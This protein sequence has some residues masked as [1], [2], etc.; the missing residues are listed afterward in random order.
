MSVYRMV[1]EMKVLNKTLF[2]NCC[3]M[4]IIAFVYL[5]AFGPMGKI[6]DGPVLK[7]CTGGENI[8]LQIAVTQDSDIQAY[9][10]KL[11]RSGAFG[12]FFFCEQCGF[13]S[14][15][16]EE[17]KERGHAVGLYVCSEHKGQKTDMYIGGGHSVPVLH[18][19]QNGSLRQIGPSID[20]E[21]L[22]NMSNW[23]QLFSDSLKGDMFIRIV[24]DNQ[25]DEFEKVVQ[26]V[27]DKGYT[28][29]KVDEML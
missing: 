7:G 22:R 29:L 21:R 8:A 2:S 23:L 26:I 9:M 15:D 3:L 1:K 10:E 13:G 6:S 17:I 14:A 4:L 28:I 20:L 19:F 18:Y 12:T 25:F 5:A 24:A 11:E 27:S 16:T